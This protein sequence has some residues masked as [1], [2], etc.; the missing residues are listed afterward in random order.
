MLDHIISSQFKVQKDCCSEHCAIPLE[1]LADQIRER[2][3]VVRAAL[4]NALAAALDAGDALIEAQTRVPKGKWQQWLQ[5][6]C[7]LG[8]ST[9]KLY[10]R[11]ARGRG[12]I[13]HEI[14]RAG[15]LSIRAVRKLLK[16]ESSK[17]EPDEPSENAPEESESEL[18]PVIQAVETLKALSNEQL[19][20]V[21]DTLTLAPFLRTISVDLRSELER[22]IAGLRSHAKGG[23]KPALQRESEILRQALSHIRIAAMPETTPAGAKLAEA[24]ALQA[25]RVLAKALGAVDIDN[26]TLI[27]RF[28]KANR[29]VKETRRAKE[30]RRRAA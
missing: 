27:D 15:D 9:A 6:N 8:L 12:R 14:E 22:R 19:T 1:E 29:C 4:A 18:D 26:V 20:R 21:W 16:D 28:A 17:N 10:M 13:E 3:K 7:F 24:Q 2:H 25:L 5:K 11:F 30:R 23:G